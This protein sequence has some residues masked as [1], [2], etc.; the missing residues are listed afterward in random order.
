MELGFEGR[1][2]FKGRSAV[3]TAGLVILFLP[4][5]SL[6][7][8]NL[9]QNGNFEVGGGSF[10]DW[11][12]SHDEYQSNYSGPTIVS[13]G[14]NDPYYARF[15][16]E[17]EANDILSQDILT[18]PGDIYEISFDAEDGDGHN[19]GT[20][21]D[22]GNFQADLNNT[23]ET[24]PGTWLAGWTNFN[25]YATATQDESDLS[26]I[27]AADTGSEF[28]VDDISVVAVP[29]VMAMASGRNFQVTVTNCTS[30]V[31]IQASTN[32]LNWVTV[33]TNT[34]PYTFTDVACAKFPQ[35]FYRAA[36]LQVAQQ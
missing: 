4:L 11:Q 36:V 9:V 30:E 1:F 25:F 17:T 35:R 24:G 6:H 18:V 31:I 28:G 12:I 8:Q 10:A 16:F 33:C 26:F 2:W 29:K 27:I 14:D 22:F 34:A 3:L 13:G 23:F 5:F 20:Y 21:F 19:F 15:Q 32:M 7:S